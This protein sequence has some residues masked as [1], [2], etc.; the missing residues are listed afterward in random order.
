[1]RLVPCLVMMV[2]AARA[3]REIGKTW[4]PCGCRMEFSCLSGGPGA[5]AGGPASCWCWSRVLE[6][7]ESLFPLLFA[8]RR[9]AVCGGLR[10]PRGGCPDCP[11][12]RKLGGPPG[13]SEWPR[14]SCKPCGGGPPPWLGCPEIAGVVKAE[15]GWETRSVVTGS[16]SDS[17]TPGRVL[18]GQRLPGRC[19]DHAFS[20]GSTGGPLG[21]I[22]VAWGRLLLSLSPRGPLSVEQ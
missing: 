13:R 5:G 21:P 11:G 20:I 12:G 16:C 22:P 19:R 15:S 7:G 17:V 10:R 6:G 3:G 9:S 8:V 2:A 4:G 1:V 14:G 18:P